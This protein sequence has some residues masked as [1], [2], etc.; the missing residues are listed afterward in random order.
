MTNQVSKIF[1]PGRGV[2][3]AFNINSLTPTIRS[4]IIFECDH[5][6]HTMVIAQSTP[7]MVA[8]R[9]LSEMSLTTTISDKKSKRTRV[10]VSCKIIEYI[11]K[12]QLSGDSITKAL[13][14]RYSPS[15]F[16]GNIRSAYRHSAGQE[17]NITGMVVFQKKEYVSG[18]NFRLLDISITGTGFLI[19]KTVRRKKNPLMQIRAGSILKIKFVLISALPEQ[20]IKKVDVEV[21]GRA[22]RTSSNYSELYGFVGLK[23]TKISRKNEIILSQFVHEAQLFELKKQPFQVKN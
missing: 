23:F 2:E 15:M 19:P 22:I 17:F 12:Y 6:G 4:S 20:K 13:R 14:V 21:E 7:P 10:G 11:K 16:E 3:I 1:T 5:S 9:D 18:K 8:G